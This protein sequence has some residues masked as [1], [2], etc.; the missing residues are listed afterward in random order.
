MSK[1]GK[2][3]IAIKDGVEVKI[4]NQ[5]VTIKGPKG[6]LSYTLLDGVLAKVEDNAIVVSITDDEKKN[7]WGLTRTLLSNMEHGVSEGFEKKL[8]LMGVGYS[9]KKEGDGILFALGFSH[10]VK[11][12]IPSSLQCD[13]EQDAKGNYVITLKGIDKQYLGEVTAKI[14]ALKKPEPYKGKGIRYIDEV[15]K[16][17]AGKTAKK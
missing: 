17:K 14:R 9:A 5:T 10:K 16:L 7:L 11:F 15:V 1:I 12:D 13:V 2:K 8:L 6:T 4:E 3:P